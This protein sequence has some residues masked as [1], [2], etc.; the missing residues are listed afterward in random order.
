[1][2][3]K[4]GKEVVGAL[5]VDRLYVPGYDLDEDVRLL[6][7]VASM[8]AQAVKLRRTAQ[9]ERERLEQENERLRSELRDRFRPANIIGNSHEMQE[10]YDQIAQVSQQPDHGA[11]RRARPARARSSW[12]TRSTTTATGPTSRSSRVHCAA[13]PE[14]VI[15]SELFG[16]EKGAFTGA[17]DRAQG[18]L[19][20]WPTAARCSSTR[21]ARSPRRIQIKLLRVLQERE[22]ERVG[23]TRDD[24]GQRARHRRHQPGPARPWSRRAASARTSST[25]STSSRST[26]PPLRKRK[27]DIVLLADHFLEKYASDDGKNVRRLSSAAIDMLI[28]LPLA[29]QRA[30]AG[31]LHRARRARGRGRRDPPAPP[32]PDPAD[33]RGHRRRPRG[34]LKDLVAAYERDLIR[35]AL[36]STRGNMAAAARALGSTPRILGYKVRQYGIE[37]RKYAG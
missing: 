26:C 10:V 20:D 13:L 12:P 21:S 25:G 3:I 6:T 31:E 30:G 27:A 22:F 37:P 36:K 16:H 15:E 2:P 34:R 8:I 5:S 9:E 33:G 23:G 4:V 14:S 11:D 35:D 29:G 32:A 24:Q 19:R 17:I 18:A 28:A 7:I 1:M